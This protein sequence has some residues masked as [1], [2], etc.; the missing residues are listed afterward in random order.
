[1]NGTQEGYF[2]E[3]QCDR[4]NLKTMANPLT[5]PWNGHH[6]LSLLV[7]LSDLGVTMNDMTPDESKNDVV[8]WYCRTPADEVVDSLE[9]MSR[10]P[11]FQAI[12]QF[13]ELAHRDPEGLQRALDAIENGWK[14][15]D[16][17]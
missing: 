14:P 10:E 5:A 1:M 7:Y 17:T 8:E 2:T 4:M 15:G 3:E 13:Q 12:L 9:T 11:A 6:L 16:P